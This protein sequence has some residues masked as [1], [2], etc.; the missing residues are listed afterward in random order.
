MLYSTKL[1]EHCKPAI[2]E[3]NKNHYIK[4]VTKLKKKYVKQKEKSNFLDQIQRY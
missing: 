4:K 1:T 2:T 3:K